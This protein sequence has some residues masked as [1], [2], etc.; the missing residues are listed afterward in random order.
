MLLFFKMKLRKNT[1]ATV[2]LFFPDT[3]F[4]LVTMQYNLLG[5]FENAI[6]FF[7]FTWNYDKL[8]MHMYAIGVAMCDFEKN[9]LFKVHSTIY[10]T[11][12]LKQ[13]HLKSFACMSILSMLRHGCIPDIKF[14]TCWIYFLGPIIR[15][16][17]RC[18][19]Q[20]LQK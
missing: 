15:L 4:L 12:P 17:F 10:V 18:F 6:S 20:F 7:F 5:E 3:L 14:G 1:V 8:L 2:F 11:Y 16:W 13:E 19:K 9:F